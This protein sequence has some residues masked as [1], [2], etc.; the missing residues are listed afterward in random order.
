MERKKKLAAWTAV[1]AILIASCVVV[2][3]SIQKRRRIAIQGVVVRQD[4]DPGKQS[5]V[6]AVQITATTGLTVE[7]STSG[8]SGY[9]RI[10]LPR[11]FR[12]HQ[13]VTLLFRHTDYHPIEVKEQVSDQL[14][15]IH[16]QPIASGSPPEPDHP[17]VFISNVRIR[18]SIKTMTQPNVGSAVKTFQIANVGNVPCQGRHPCSPDGKWKATIASTSIDAGDGNQFRNAR[19]SCIAGPCPFT[20][21]EVEDLSN[22]GRTLNLSARAWSDTVTFLLEAEVVH[23]MVSD[24]VRESY[25]VI[26]GQTLSFSL[27][28]SAEGPSVEAEINGEA[29]IF[30]LGPDLYLSWAQCSL[31]TSKDLSKVYQC[32]LKPKCRFR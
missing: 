1:A 15:V 7:Q 19:V 10:L 13:S 26:F 2:V 25:P 16:L 8:S 22:G 28:A 30:P 31:G 14:F 6:S 4:A 5:P 3:I 20:R 29:I 24:I 12:R 27:P 11:G 17:T 9:F 23:P 18:Y 32:E 21:I